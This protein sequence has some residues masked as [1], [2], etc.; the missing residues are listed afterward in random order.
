MFVREDVVDAFRIP[1]AAELLRDTDRVHLSLS[2]KRGT[3]DPVPVAAIALLNEGD[4]DP[5]LERVPETDA[6]RDLWTVSFKLPTDD[7]Q[8]RCFRAV[9]A[10][11]SSVTT[12]SLTR[13]RRLEDLRPTLDCLVD[14][15]RG[16]S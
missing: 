15:V 1:G 8:A 5:K 4:T 11:A 7:D 3:C 12:W 14:A 16:G 10:L 2:S 13:R 6:V 9:V